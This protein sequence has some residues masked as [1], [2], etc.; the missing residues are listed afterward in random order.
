MEPLKYSLCNLNFDCILYIIFLAKW[1]WVKG[2]RPIFE[3]PALQWLY[4][5]YISI[6][7]IHDIIFGF[8][9]QF[10]LLFRQQ[11]RQDIRISKAVPFS[12]NDE[13]IWTARKGPLFYRNSWYIFV[14]I[15]KCIGLQTKTLKHELFH[16]LWSIYYIFNMV[17][18]YLHRI[19]KFIIWKLYELFIY[20]TSDSPNTNYYYLFIYLF[21]LGIYLLA[22]SHFLLEYK[23]QHNF[24]QSCVGPIAANREKK[25]SFF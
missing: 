12:T 13:K 17:K 15:P 14:C 18:H 24:V 10:S 9:F 19:L 21:I 22:Y 7:S 20:L 23:S 6:C 16:F 5:V 1:D 25:T 8:I 3:L 4:R 11:I 2:K